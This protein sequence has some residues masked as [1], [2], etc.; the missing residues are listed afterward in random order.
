MPKTATFTTITPLPA[1]IS[2]Q[3][4]LDMYRDH[5]AMID[6]NPLVVERYKC[7]PPSYAPVE[8]FY[9]TWYTIK[10]ML[11]PFAVQINSD[12]NLDKVSYLPGGFA[13]SSV[14][15]HACFDDLHDG[16]HTHVYAPLGLDIR[17]R[18][19]VGGGKAGETNK[20]SEK[21]PKT[22]RYGLYIREDVQMTCSSLLMSFVKRTFKD[23]HASLVEQ[24]VE[25]AHLLEST[26]ANERLR[27]LRNVDPGERMAIGD[28]YIAP[29][30]DYLPSRN[31]SPVDDASSQPPPSPVHRTHTSPHNSAPNLSSHAR[32]HSDPIASPGLSQTS[33]LVEDIDRLRTRWKEDDQEMVLQFA[34]VDQSDSHMSS[35]HSEPSMYFLPTTTYDNTPPPTLQRQRSN[36]APSSHQQN[37]KSSYGL[38]P[39]PSTHHRNNSNVSVRPPRVS[40]HP[41][42]RPISFTF[43]LAA[44][45]FDTKNTSATS[46]MNQNILDEIDDAIDQMCA[47]HADIQPQTLPATTYQPPATLPRTVYEPP[48]APVPVKQKRRE[49]PQ[50]HK[51][52]DSCM[53]SSCEK[54][55]PPL[56]K[57]AF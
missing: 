13:Q 33:T 25:R 30:P 40:F 4:V 9:S 27:A 1:G 35:S 51:R 6:L 50:Q 34:V 54:E 3:A 22:P 23:S 29:P 12:F 49:S 57:E 14:S 36:T 43:P 20:P 39:R 41:S 44:S 42:Q 7:R 11:D 31:G 10:G 18:W 5:M 21:G 47:Y 53:R 16:L 56:P 8:E 24:L 38:F 28:I 45:E 17:A 26:I 52:N 19:T 37:K 15:Y 48:S 2:R 46:P 32:S 55:L